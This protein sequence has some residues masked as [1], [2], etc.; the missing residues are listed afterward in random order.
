MEPKQLD[1]FEGEFYFSSRFSE[2]Y[3]KS[4]PDM[5]Q[6]DVKRI[7][8]STRVELRKNLHAKINGIHANETRVRGL[9]EYLYHDNMGEY[10]LFEY[11]EAEGRM[12][13]KHIKYAITI[14]TFED[15]PEDRQLTEKVICLV[16]EIAHVYYDDGTLLRIGVFPKSQM[17]EDYIN[18]KALEFF[19]NN[20]V[21]SLRLYIDSREGMPI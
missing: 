1:F 18:Y 8:K 11:Q 16:H 15:Y 6:K 9:L 2:A 4:I 20:R 13:D 5:T 19:G 14:D 7:M 17:C 12:R 21:F 10:S 3:Y